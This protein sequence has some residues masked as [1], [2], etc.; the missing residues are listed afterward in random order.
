M[1]L[2]TRDQARF[3]DDY[4][5]KKLH[6]KGRDLMNSAGKAIADLILGLQIDKISDRIAILC[7]KGNNG[8]DGF[9]TALWL[10]RKKVSTD[11]YLFA[12]KDDLKGDAL[13][14]F[15][16]CLAKK[17][18]IY[19]DGII[20]DTGQYRIVIDAFLGTGFS[21]ELPYSAKKWFQW[22]HGE[23]AVVI[24]ADI[25]SGINAD[26]GQCAEGTIRADYTVTMGHAKLGMVIGEGKRHSGKIVVAD[27]G[28]PNKV[29]YTGIN[30]E[31]MDPQ[32]IHAF[33]DPPALDTHKARQGKVL[34]I[35]GSIG[36][37]G[38]AILSGKAALKSGAG[39]VV[40][41]VPGSLNQI[42]ETQLL[43]VMTR[44]V[45][46][47]GCG[48]FRSVNYEE[49]VPFLE[50]C[51]VLV[52]G[53]G[54]GRYDETGDL[55]SM[56]LDNFIK[57]AVI[58]AD[59]LYFYKANDKNHILTPHEYEFR[60]LIGKSEPG[61]KLSQIHSFVND[62]KGIL[63]YKGAPTLTIKGNRGM[64][65][66]TGNPGMATAGSGDVLSGIIA[67]FAA[68]GYDLYDAAAM[69]VYIHGYA[70]DTCVDKTGYRG[71]NASDIVTAL[72]HA[73]SEFE[74]SAL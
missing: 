13:H 11:L 72:P 66:T 20:P 24:S 45:D 69:G 35:G 70:A 40:N 42:Y 57:P 30:W 4:A 5:I 18:P 6:I 71:L 8:G 21:G 52:I 67:S 64:V 22:V 38:A 39:L 12:G 43:E 74:L 50:W 15:E 26:T 27:I 44:P 68:Q 17:I 59:A 36:M 54:L 60:N 1:R 32:N 31:D 25:A 7:G 41:V 49:I 58:D 9:A 19:S 16:L 23:K 33:L 3:L 29:R 73:I 65:N 37:T 53:P 62:Y 10:N 47:A 55:I 48:Y 14:F 34:I 28:F 56:I 2:L 61:D 63:V 46:D 51:D